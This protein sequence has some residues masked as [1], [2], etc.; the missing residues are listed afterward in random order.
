MMK[1]LF[2][3]FALSLTLSMAA[4]D[5]HFTQ[6]YASPLTLNP[7]LSG[8][9]EGLYRAGVI[10]R[11]QWRQAL[12]RPYATS[13]AMIDLR[14]KAPGKLQR[15][16][17]VGVGLLFFN[18]KVGGLDFSTTN[19]S[20]AG[21][22]HKSL[23]FLSNQYLSAG[24]QIGITQRN[25]SYEYLNFN[26]QFNGTDGY[27]VPTSEV[28]PENNFAYADMALGL[29]YSAYFDRR[30]GIYAGATIHHFNGPNVSFYSDD[31]NIP[32][33]TLYR[34][35]TAHVGGQILLGERLMMI[36]RVLFRKQGPHYETNAGTNFRFPVNETETV[37][38]HLGSWVRTASRSENSWGTEAIVGLVGLEFSNILLGISY[39]MNL[40]TINNGFRRNALE[41]SL[42]YLGEYENETVLCPQF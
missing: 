41:V 19:M 22:Y 15:R 23:S 21:A 13:S 26:D 10:Y 29:N 4:Q 11:D 34:K 35:Y 20:I 27:T 17:K 37:A 40:G 31:P 12:E 5:Q 28:L 36:P 33:N 39:D 3:I 6:F 18:D 24:F 32:S 1:F 38:M 2:S 25:V 14:L 42:T 9:F 8:N 7:A 30:S 16:D